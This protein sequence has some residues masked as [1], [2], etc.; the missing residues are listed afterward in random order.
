MIQPGSEPLWSNPHSFP[1]SLLLCGPAW[2][3]GA[4]T[5]AITVLILITF[6]WSDSANRKLLMMDQ[7]GKEVFFFFY[8]LLSLLICLPGFFLGE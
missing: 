5:T 3:K 4:I 7:R 1:L 2:Y 6:C 8:L